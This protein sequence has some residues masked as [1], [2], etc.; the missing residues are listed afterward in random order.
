MQEV[1]ATFSKYGGNLGETNSVS[2]NFQRVAE[3]RLECSLS[4][5]SLLDIAISAGAHNAEVL[6]ED[7]N[8]FGALIHCAVE[9]Q[10]AVASYLD[11]AKLTVAEQHIVFLPSTT[12]SVED[13]D[14]IKKLTKL[15]DTFDDNDDVQQVFHNALLPD[16]DE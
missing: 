9:D 10:F 7:G 6:E 2:W 3:I 14:H 15:L 13:A 4:E 16:Q 1:R 8:I 12:V 5:E 11:N